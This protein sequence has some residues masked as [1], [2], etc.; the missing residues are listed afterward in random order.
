LLAGLQCWPDISDFYSDYPISHGYWWYYIRIWYPH[1]ISVLLSV[2][3]NYLD[4]RVII[5]ISVQIHS[6]ERTVK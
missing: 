3:E 1:K 4:I 2:S 6:V 5:H